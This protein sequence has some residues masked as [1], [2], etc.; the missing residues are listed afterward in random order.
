METLLK[1]SRPGVFSG[2]EK[3]PSLH[4][5]WSLGEIKQHSEHVAIQPY[6][7]KRRTMQFCWR[8]ELSRFCFSPD[9]FYNSAFSEREISSF[10]AVSCCA[11]DT[12]IQ[13]GTFFGRPNMFE[14]C[15]NILTGLN[16]HHF[17]LPLVET[18]TKLIKGYIHA[19]CFL[20][21]MVLECLKN[22]AIFVASPQFLDKKQKPMSYYP[23]S[24]FIHI[25]VATELRAR[26]LLLS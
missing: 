20:L 21:L 1:R 12:P 14:T 10:D 4:C 3:I 13:E 17:T 22:M 18:Q 11:L 24:I 19:T 6:T 23:R 16:P 2:P 9:K 15:Q 8:A 26:G 7:Q 25:A 5:Y